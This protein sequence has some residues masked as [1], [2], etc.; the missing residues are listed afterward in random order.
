MNPL[1]RKRVNT[2]CVLRDSTMNRRV[3]V[4][5]F[6]DGD[7]EGTRFKRYSTVTYIYMDTV[8][9]KK[10]DNNQTNQ[11]RETNVSGTQRITGN[12]RIISLPSF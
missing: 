2:D 11:N 7:D 3:N 5:R 1:L 6:T 9:R 8:R 10:R 4:E 12:T